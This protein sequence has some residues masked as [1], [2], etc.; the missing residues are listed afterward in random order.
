MRVK[1]GSFVVIFVFAFAFSIITDISSNQNGQLVLGVQQ[2]LAEGDGDGGDGGGDSGGYYDF[3][4]NGYSN[5]PTCGPTTCTNGATNYPYCNNNVCTNGATNYPACNNNVCTNG[6]TNYPACNNQCVPLGTQTRYSSCPTGQSGQITEQRTHTCPSNVWGNWMVTG[7]TCTPN[8]CTN[9]ATNYPACNNVCT[10]GYSNYPTCGPTTCTNGATNFPFCN[11]NV[12]TNGANNYPFCNNNTCTNGATNYPFCNNNTC[13]N[14]ASNYPQCNNVCTN[15]YS[16][17]PTCG[18]TTCTNG[19]SNFPYCNNVCTNGYSNYPTCGPTTCGNGCNNYPSCNSCPSGMIFKDGYCQYY[20]FYSYVQPIYTPPVYVAPVCN[21]PIVSTNDS[22]SYS[23]S[24]TIFGHITNNDNNSTIWFQYGTSPAYL[25]WEASHE[26][27]YSS[28][29]FSAS[30]TGL[31]CGTR[32]YYRAVAQNN[33]STQKGEIQSFVTN[34]CP[35]VYYPPTKK[36]IVKKPV[37]VKPKAVVKNPGTCLCDTQQYLILTISSVEQYSTIG[38]IENFKVTFKNPSKETLKDL[39]IRVTLPEG[40]TMKAAQ[41]GQFTAGGKELIVTIPSLPAD[42]NGEFYFTVDVAGTVEAGKQI[43]VNT[44]GDYT[45]P[46]VVKQ[47][48]PLK[49]E[50]NA[51]VLTTTNSAPSSITNIFNNSTNSSS[52]SFWSWLPSN[53]LDWVI[54]ILVLLVF[55]SALRYFI[56]I[57]TTSTN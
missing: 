37:V 31:N 30:I 8:T 42:Q 28:G 23:N 43:I 39:A 15:G 26:R 14:G 20:S 21:R 18:P 54:F 17:Y 55:F 53:I 40:L 9:G 44:Y 6:A 12:C 38:G 3:C 25:Q 2:V 19:A 13:T 45:V 52:S 36:P 22:N 5:Y 7:N 29:R 1:V 48:V 16:N 4:T 41:A 50:V 49:G 33:C 10:N 34:S 56:R 11:N 24:A 51:Y 27:A 35:V 57:F 47:G 46:T 32:Y